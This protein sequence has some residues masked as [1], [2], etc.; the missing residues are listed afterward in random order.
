MIE[1]LIAEFTQKMTY[2]RISGSTAHEIELQ[3]SYIEILNYIISDLTSAIRGRY[4][5]KAAAWLTGRTV[6][7]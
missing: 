5:S 3:K 7:R 2:E 4:I 1:Q 6:I